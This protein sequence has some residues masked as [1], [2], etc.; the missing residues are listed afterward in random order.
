MLI[1]LRSPR[2]VVLLLVLALG[3]AAYLTY[4]IGRRAYLNWLVQKSTKDSLNRAIALDGGNCDAYYRL[5]LYHAFIMDDLDLKRGRELLLS[6]ARCQPLQARYWLALATA[7]EAGGQR[8]E[9]LAA[10]EK[11]A[12]LQS[13]NA[14]ILWQCGNLLLRIG[15]LEA[16]FHLFY[17]VLQGAPEYA[18]Q[19]FNACLK[20]T[21]DGDLI[22]RRAVPDTVDLDLAYLTFLSS[23]ENLNVDAAGKVW[24]RLMNLG[25]PFASERAF[26]YFDA[27]LA[28]GRAGEAV[29]HWDQM[30]LIG[31]LPRG[32]LHRSDDLIVN[33][34]FEVT[35]ANGGLDWRIYPVGG[36]DVRTSTQV[37]HS[38]ARS[39]VLRFEGLT[40]VDFQ[41]VAQIVPVAPSAKYQFSGFMKSQALSTL[42]G[43]HFEIFD[44]KD[45]R[46]L[47]WETADVLSTTEWSEYRLAIQTGPKTQVLVVR[48]RRK[49]AVELDKRIEGTLWVD[50]VNLSPQE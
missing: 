12:V 25:R 7:L 40:N 37:R 46:T 17:R 4:Q 9:A 41:Q 15:S 30:V 16:A 39:L 42:S 28:A 44:P 34:G 45:P 24:V 36:V 11:A 8:D 20:S 43:P 10:T 18:P 32:E 14:T 29:E 21:R 13:R 27:L 6:A 33:G 31:V 35:P 5:G 47:H 48:L 50:D 3:T 23:A 26:P 49:P 1:R 19:V 38:G 2:S 22:L